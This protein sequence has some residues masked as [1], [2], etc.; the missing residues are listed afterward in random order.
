[1]HLTVSDVWV[2]ESVGGEDPAEGGD[3]HLVLKGRVLGERAVQISLYLL[4]GQVV[5]AHGLL[6]QVFIVS[7]VS[8][9]L[10]DRPCSERFA[11]FKPA[12]LSHKGNIHPVP[13]VHTI[14]FL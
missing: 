13:L 8:G 14:I 12:I 2:S 10:V 9:H 3:A 1:M 11:C 4:R 6:H 5:F 7:W